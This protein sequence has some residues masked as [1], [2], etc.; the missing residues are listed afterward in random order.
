[1]NKEYIYQYLH[2]NNNHKDIDQLIDQCIDEVKN[3]SLFKCVYQRL[4]LK[5]HPL[6]INEYL[7]DNQDLNY[8]LKD[9]DEVII[10]GCTLGS[11]IDRK[12]KYYEKIDMAKA[13]VFD[14]VASS[15]LEQCCDE[16][17]KRFNLSKRTFRLAPGYGNIPLEYNL[18]LS[19]ILNIQSSLYVDINSGGIMTPMKSMLGI[20][21]VGANIKKTC[22]SCLN[23]KHCLLKKEGMTCY[24]KD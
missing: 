22:M 18:Y 2:L 20:I 23:E 24:V 4:K 11:E 13:V 12:I 21:G 1:M 10:I 9:C 3:L 15:Y 7:L 6:R 16:Y 5:H 19:K 14:A 8:Y 17:E